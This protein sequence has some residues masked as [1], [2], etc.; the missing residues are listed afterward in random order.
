M[1]VGVSCRQARC[2]AL[3]PMTSCHL[4]SCGWDRH[5]SATLDQ[6]RLFTIL[7]R[8]RYGSIVCP[9]STRS[10]SIVMSGGGGVLWSEET[11]MD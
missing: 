11:I 9:T 5:R 8:S 6:S 4:A 1:G 7:Y 2:R 10:Y 3:K